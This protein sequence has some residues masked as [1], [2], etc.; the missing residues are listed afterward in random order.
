MIKWAI[1]KMAL[2]FALAIMFVDFVISSRD[3]NYDNSLT[4]KI[5]FGLEIV[6]GFVLM[7]DRLYW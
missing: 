5:I 1:I 3:V 7:I 6:L 4:H 2:I